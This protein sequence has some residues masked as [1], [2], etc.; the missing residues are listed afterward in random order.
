MKRLYLF[1]VFACISFNINAQNVE[2]PCNFQ[3]STDVVKCEEN[4][5]VHLKFA[6]VKWD[7]D[8]VST[9]QANAKIEIVPILD[10]WEEVNGAQTKD[11]IAIVVD[12]S[13]LKGQTEVKLTQLSAKCFKWRTVITTPDCTTQTDWKYHS[14][15]PKKS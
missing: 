6:T 3:F 12:A 1:C 4:V 11:M 13:H 15:I 8:H 10:C 7:F 2:N 9:A 14:F 5:P